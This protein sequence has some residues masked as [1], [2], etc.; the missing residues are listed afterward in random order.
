MTKTEIMERL[1]KAA[2]AQAEKKRKQQEAAKALI[3]KI[4]DRSGTV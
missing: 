1:R 3:A 4:K 2:E